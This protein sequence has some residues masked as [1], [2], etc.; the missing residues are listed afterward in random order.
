MD[1]KPNMS[2]CESCHYWMKFTDAAYGCHFCLIEKQLRNCKPEVCDKWKPKE[3]RD[4]V[5]LKL[6]FAL[7]EKFAL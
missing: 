1:E 7:G 4:P 2:R 5:Q 6:N 3:K